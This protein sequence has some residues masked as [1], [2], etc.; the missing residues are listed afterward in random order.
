MV[1]KTTTAKKTVEVG[2]GAEGGPFS[3]TA[4]ACA[5]NPFTTT[6]KEEWDKHLAE[7]K[8]Y[9]QGAAPCV[10]CGKEVNL[11]EVLTL[12]GRK[13]VHRECVELPEEL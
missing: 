12:A 6:D 13:P 4:G 10:I 2:A 8:H 9:L 3:C 7:S 11:Y 1:S 5:D